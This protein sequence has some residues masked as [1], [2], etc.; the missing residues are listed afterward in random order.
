MER[1]RSGSH[2]NDAF[3]K[4]KTFEQMKVMNVQSG[5]S[6]LDKVKGDIR[7]MNTKI[8]ELHSLVMTSMSPQHPEIKHPFH[9]APDQSRQRTTSMSNTGPP[10]VSCHT[11]E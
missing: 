6:D 1:E 5:D 8:N 7:Q 11:N 4:L 10:N 2:R 9:I 3:P